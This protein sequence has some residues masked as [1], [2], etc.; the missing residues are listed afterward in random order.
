MFYE[1]NIFIDNIISII[2]Y[3]G[4]NSIYIYIY[5]C[6]AVM[7]NT[8]FQTQ[9]MFSKVYSVM[10]AL[11]VCILCIITITIILFKKKQQ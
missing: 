9:V 3:I 5:V 8:E 1:G 4:A 7:F 10:I 2:L 11:W 6:I